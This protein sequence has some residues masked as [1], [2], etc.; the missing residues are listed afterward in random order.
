MSGKSHPEG[1]AAVD[2]AINRVLAAEQAARTAVARCGEQARGLRDQAEILAKRITA[3]NERRLG[4]VQRIAD[5]SVSRALKAL[6]G[7]RAPGT[8]EPVPDAQQ[9]ERLQAAVA[10]LLDEMVGTPE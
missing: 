1:S 3:R 8:R 5:R 10:A 4:A 6:V 2:A 7:E 9:M